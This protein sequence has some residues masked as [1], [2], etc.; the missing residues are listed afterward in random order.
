MVVEASRCSKKNL[1][2]SLT[3]LSMLIHCRTTTIDSHCAQTAA[4]RPKHL[5]RLHGKF[6]SGH[7]HDDLQR[8]RSLIDELYKRQQIGQ[9][10]AS[11]RR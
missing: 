3:Q 11:S 8:G 10:L 2:L 9:R 4:H 1:W 5:S 6:A 7:Y